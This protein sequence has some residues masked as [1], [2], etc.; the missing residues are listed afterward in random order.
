MKIK[1]FSLVLAA[2]VSAYTV[3]DLLR[4]YET[5]SLG[6]E[7]AKRKLAGEYQYLVQKL[8]K[9]GKLYGSP[10][11]GTFGPLFDLLCLEHAELDCP[12]IPRSK[13]KEGTR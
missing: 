2:V 6:D 8:A 4:L 13:P 9:E 12:R 3:S 1:F 11:S 10:S 5:A 7:S